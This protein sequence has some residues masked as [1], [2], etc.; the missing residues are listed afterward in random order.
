MNIST[1]AIISIVL[2]VVIFLI[3]FVF[4]RHKQTTR[5]S[6]TT[7]TFV[8]VNGN[9]L[10]N[11]NPAT[12]LYNVSTLNVTIHSAPEKTYS[13]YYHVKCIK[14]TTNYSTVFVTTNESGT[15]SFTRSAPEYSTCN[16][17]ITHVSIYGPG[18]LNSYSITVINSKS[19]TRYSTYVVV[20]GIELTDT[21]NITTLYN[22]STLKI[23]I[24]GYPNSSYLTEYNIYCEKSNSQTTVIRTSEFIKTNSSG[25]TTFTKSAPT[26]SYCNTTET[27]ISIVGPGLQNV[28]NITVINGEK[29]KH[30]RNT[31]YVVVN[32]VTLNNL[33]LWTTFYNISTINATIY[34]SSPDET[35]SVFYR[36]YCIT[37]GDNYYIVTQTTAYYTTNI[38]GITTFTKPAPNY[39]T[40]I[41][42]QTYLAISGPGLYYTLTV[43]VINKRSS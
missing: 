42:T 34:S 17:T 39:S 7:S 35:Y 28:V 25:I 40:C 1:A 10:T 21:K 8:V 14:G 20:N 24:H 9:T 31:T 16:T 18:I 23:T 30:L 6:T 2:I 22:V 36:V 15:A 5:I 32:G 27:Y 11:S 33:T 3:F 37:T 43:D 12:T 29:V 4:L 13:V 38:Y 26:Y 41:T 19:I